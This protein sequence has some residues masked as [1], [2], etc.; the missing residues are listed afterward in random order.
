MYL[1]LFVFPDEL[2]K[3]AEK[4]YGTVVTREEMLKDKILPYNQCA[5]VFLK[6]HY[7]SL[8]PGFFE[9]A[10]DATLGDD[11]YIKYFST[12]ND[13]VTNKIVQHYHPDKEQIAFSQLDSSA[14]ARITLKKPKYGYRTPPRNALHD[15]ADEL[16]RK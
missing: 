10:N 2:R 12:T 13:E 11:A 9:L 15:L 5:T 14:Q 1:R 8:D 16:N 4:G 7:G 6:P 3:L